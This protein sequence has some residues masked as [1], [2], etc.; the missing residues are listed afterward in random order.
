MKN[1]I[2]SFDVLPFVVCGYRFSIIELEENIG[3]VKWYI[4]NAGADGDH[5]FLVSLFI[6]LRRN[7]V[8]SYACTGDVS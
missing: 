1:A 6:S 3:R 8:F 7:G 4:T 5:R 2:N